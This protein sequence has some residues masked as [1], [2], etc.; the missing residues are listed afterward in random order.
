M[1]ERVV[2]MEPIEVIGESRMVLVNP[3]SDRDYEDTVSGRIFRFPPFKRF[4]VDARVAGLLIANAIARE[5]D[6][7]NQSQAEMEMYYTMIAQKNEIMHMR[8]KKLY[9]DD[10]GKVPRTK[11]WDFPPLLNLNDPQGLKIFHEAVEAAVAKGVKIE[12]E[13]TSES[14]K[15]MPLPKKP[16]GSWTNK[17]Y[18]NFL[19]EWGGSGNYPE[20]EDRLYRKSMALFKAWFK[21]RERDG[22]GIIDSETGEVVRRE[23]LN[24]DPLPEDTDGEN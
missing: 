13:V 19:N 16:G 14:F 1:D 22:Y 3:N 15:E 23:D 7:K 17:E 21:D 20:P 2:R 18:V 11:P 10:N 6:A 9:C 12:Q 4:S 5:Q 8:A 24:L